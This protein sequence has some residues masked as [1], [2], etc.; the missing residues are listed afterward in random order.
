MQS[1]GNV[2]DGM[3]EYKIVYGTET[4]MVDKLQQAFTQILQSGVQ[5]SLLH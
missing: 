5:V 2:T 3:P 1:L 4:E